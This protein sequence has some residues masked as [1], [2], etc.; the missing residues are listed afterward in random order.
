MNVILSNVLKYIMSSDELFDRFYNLLEEHKKGVDL[1]D[2]RIPKPEIVFRNRYTSFIN[3][4][5]FCKAINRDHNLVQ[6]YIR[7]EFNKSKPTLDRNNV[8]RITGRLS[9]DNIQTVMKRFIKTYVQC[10]QCN[11]KNTVIRKK[12]KLD[13]MCCQNCSS[14]K[15]IK[16]KM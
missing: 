11:S 12:N 9:N 2:V 16:L 1:K 6:R 7:K 8:L 13:T 15:H 14:E 10:E 3:F 4:D 5:S